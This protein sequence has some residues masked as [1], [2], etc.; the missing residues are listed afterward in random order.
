MD[1]QHI[2]DSI[3][4][5]FCGLTNFKQRENILE[6]ITAYSTLNNKFI[7]IFVKF[8][9]DRF[10]V[11]DA[12]WIDKNIYDTPTFDESEDILKRIINNYQYN[13][14]IKTTIDA[15]GNLY[16]YKDCIS[17]EQLPGL[18]FDLANF[19]VGV[20]N[21][22][23]IQFKDPKEEKERETFKKDANIFLKQHF[24]KS[25][26]VNAPLDD[27]K[28]IK[29]NAIVSNGEKLVLI[30]YVTG[31]TQHYFESDL[32]KSIVNFEITEKSKYKNNIKEKIT[33]INNQSNGYNTLKSGAILNLLDE[34]TT[35]PPIIWSEKEKIL[36]F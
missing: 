1:I 6:V 12:G 23:F 9:K 30:S 21:S 20:V 2:K 34:K 10:V 11:T 7:S 25:L 24:G 4:E 18:I 14:E 26:K 19:S 28:N 27:F 8:E 33:L 17:P 13:Y 31:S 22:F 3:K 36:A 35:R 29:F 32:R 15:K 16:Y 5:T